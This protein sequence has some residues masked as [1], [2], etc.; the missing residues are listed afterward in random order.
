MEGPLQPCGVLPW[1]T[2]VLLL[3][4]LAT[5]SRAAAP[6]RNL[7]GRG[8]GFSYGIG[9]QFGPSALPTNYTGTYCWGER[10]W[11]QVS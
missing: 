6:N 5:V 10:Q 9:Y 11:R 8:M 4:L 7:L 3:L 1:R 2:A